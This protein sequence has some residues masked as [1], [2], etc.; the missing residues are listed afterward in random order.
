MA[1]ARSGAEHSNIQERPLGGTPIDESEWMAV[2]L[3]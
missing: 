1:Q 2:L 3:R